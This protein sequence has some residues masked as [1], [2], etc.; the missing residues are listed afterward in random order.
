[1]TRF[2]YAQQRESVF[3]SPEQSRCLFRW[4]NSSPVQFQPQPPA[5]SRPQ[6]PRFN[7][8]PQFFWFITIGSQS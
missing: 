5:E 1:M 2:C 4:A 6:K 8:D 3:Y 7:S